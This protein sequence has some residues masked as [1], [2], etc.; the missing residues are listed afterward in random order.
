MKLPNEK[1]TSSQVITLVKSSFDS[2]TDGRSAIEAKLTS[3]SADG[4][5]INVSKYLIQRQ[6]TVGKI[7]TT[8]I[9]NINGEYT[10]DTD[11]HHITQTT[12]TNY[13]TENDTECSTDAE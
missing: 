9:S 7:A 11:K 4:S 5:K 8:A 10:G 13:R 12:C 6:M 1:L 2:L 3:N